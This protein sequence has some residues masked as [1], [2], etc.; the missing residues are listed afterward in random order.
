[1]SKSYLEYVDEKSSKFYEI[2]MS[3]KKVTIRYGKIGTDGQVTIKELASAAEAKAQVEK[4][5][6]EKKKKGYEDGTNLNKNSTKKSLLKF[7]I[8]HNKSFDA[9]VIKWLSKISINNCTPFVHQLRC[10]LDGEN[11]S[12]LNYDEGDF[13]SAK[14]YNFAA[15]VGDEKNT[16]LL[17]YTAEIELSLEK[18]DEFSKALKYSK[19]Q[20]EVILGFMDPKGNIL[21]DCFEPVSDCPVH[22]QIIK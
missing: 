15:L 21:D 20:V 19:Y 4:L 9:D 11:Y 12:F 7:F 17:C 22:L 16:F 18:N 6:S 1:M 14:I 13:G 3:G 8:D 10:D 2:S 5:I